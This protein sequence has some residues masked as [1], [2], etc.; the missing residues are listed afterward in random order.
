[1]RISMFLMA[2]FVA[3][4]LAQVPDTVPDYSWYTGNSSPYTISTARQLAGLARI[5]N[6][7]AGGINT[8][9]F[10][11]KEIKLT[12]NIDLSEYANW[13]PIGYNINNLSTS[14]PFKGTF[15][16]NG[17]VIKNLKIE[18]NSNAHYQGLF[19]TLSSG[20][21]ENLGVEVDIRNSSG[22]GQFYGAIAGS[23]ESGSIIRNCYSIGYISAYATVGGIAGNVDNST[24]ENCWS[25]VNLSGNSFGFE[26][27]QGGHTG[28]IVGQAYNSYTIK[29]C[30]AFMNSVTKTYGPDSTF[31]RIVGFIGTGG[32]GVLS[33]NIAYSGMT[34]PGSIISANNSQDGLS[35]TID[36]LQTASDFPTALTDDPWTYVPG[37]LPGFGE[38]VDM[39]AHLENK[40]IVTKESANF[41]A[42]RN[43]K[44]IE[45]NTAI[46]T[47]VN[48]IRDSC[49]TLCT[50]QFG[51]GT[52]VLDILQDTVSFNNTSSTWGTINLTGKITSSKK[53]APTIHI[54]L[55]SSGDL[56]VNINADIANTADSSNAV[57]LNNSRAVN[58]TGGKIEANSL[59]SY[60]AIAS[61]STAVVTISGAAE[62]TAR[63]TLGSSHAIRQSIGTININGGKVFAPEKL[64]IY[65]NG[66][67]T[68]NVNGGEISASKHTVIINESGTIN[69]NGGMV[70]AEACSG[71]YAIENRTGTINVNGGTV[72]AK[73]KYAI[74]NN[75]TQSTVILD[76]DPTITGEIL[77]HF[78]N[79]SVTKTFAPVGSKIYNISFYGEHTYGL[80]AVV[81]GAPHIANFTPSGFP[82]NKDL[83]LAVSGDDII[84]SSQFSIYEDEWY[85][86]TSKEDLKKLAD[87]VNN[88]KTNPIYANENVRYILT[89]DIDLS[90]YENWTPIGNDKFPFKNS[91][92]NGDAHV[93][94]NLT[95]TDGGDNKGLFGV[96]DGAYIENIGIENANIIGGNNVG[97]VAGSAQGS[98]I[99]NC[100]VTGR[101]RG[102]TYVGGVAGAPVSHIGKCWSSAT[103]SGVDHV[104][105]IIGTGGTVQK[106]VALGMIVRTSGSNE[107]FGRIHS[108]GNETA[109]SDNTAYAGML[110]NGETVDPSDADAISKHGNND[111]NF[112]DFDK[113]INE[114]KTIWTKGVDKLPG[115]G[116]AI[117]MPPH[118]GSPDTAAML[119]A[120]ERIRIAIQDAI[121]TQAKASDETNAENEI[122]AII[123]S[124]NLDS[125]ITV[126]IE[127]T[128]LTANVD[129]NVSVTNPFGEKGKYE[130]KVKLT[131]NIK[132]LED[133][134][135]I[136][137]T[138]TPYNFG[139]GDGSSDK[140]YEIITEEHLAN[141]ATLINNSTTNEF[142][143]GKVHNDG[144]NIYVYDG[145]H[146]KL[147]DSLDLSSYNWVPIGRTSAAHAFKGTFDGN[148][149]VISNLKVNTTSDAGLFG[150]SVC[151]TIKNVG[152]ENVDVFSDGNHT[153][154][155]VGIIEN[156]YNF[157][158]DL[159][160]NVYVTGEVSGGKNTGGIVG[161]SEIKIQ[162]SWSTAKVKSTSSSYT[163]N[164]LGYSKNNSAVPV[165][166]AALGDSII[167]ENNFG[168]IYGTNLNPSPSTLNNVAFAGMLVNDKKVTGKENDRNGKNITADSI[169]H[170]GTIGGLFTDTAIWT[171][172]NG[173]LPGFGKP[174]DMPDYLLKD[175]LNSMKFM[176]MVDSATTNFYVL[177]KLANSNNID[178]ADARDTVINFIKE[179][180]GANIPVEI[181]DDSFAMATEGTTSSLLGENGSY[182]FK[183][184]IDGTGLESKLCS[185]TI[186]ATPHI[187]FA[188]GGGG[189]EK[190][191]YEIANAGQLDIL[192]QRVNVENSSVTSKYYKLVDDIDLNAYTNWIP[193]G[194][195]SDYSFKGVF[196]GDGYTIKNLIINTS[197]SGR[198]LFGYINGGTVKNL[199]LEKVDISGNAYE[200]G[201]I[202]GS[203]SNGSVIENS[204]VIG[205]VKG[206]NNVGGIVGLN[207]GSTIKS[208]WTSVNVEGANYVGGIAGKMDNGS[209][210]ENCVAFGEKI[211]SAG[212]S[213]G[214]IAGNSIG[215]SGNIAFAQMK[216]NGDVV[217]GNSNDKHG[218]DKTINNLLMI[219]NYPASFNDAPWIFRNIPNLRTQI[220]MPEHLNLSP[221]TINIYKD[222]TEWDNWASEGKA[223]ALWLNADS[224]TEVIIKEGGSEVTKS[225]TPGT[226]Y[227]Y[228]CEHECRNSTRV[229][230]GYSISVASHEIT[231]DYYTIIFEA[232]TD[233]DVLRMSTVT[234]TYNEKDIKSGDIVLKGGNLTL[235][236]NGLGSGAYTY[237]WTGSGISDSFSDLLEI[238]S[239]S[240]SI[241]AICTI[242]GTGV[243]LL[244][245]TLQINNE[246]PEIGDKLSIELTNHNYNGKLGYT[247]LRINPTN[248]GSTELDYEPTYQVNAGDLDYGIMVKVTAP[249][250]SGTLTVT[251]NP[252]T[253]R[254]PTIT[255]FT[256]DIPQ[257]HV[258]D[259]GN[260]NG[261]GEVTGADGMGTIT[262][263]YNGK[264]TIPTNAGTYTITVDIEDGTVYKETTELI[265]GDY[266]IAQAQG[267]FTPKILNLTYNPNT[268]KLSHLNIANYEWKADTTALQMG[269]YE[270]P[271]TYTDPSGNYIP[272]DGN[273]TITL[274]KALGITVDA[275]TLSSKTTDSITII[276]VSTSNGQSAE[277]S[278]N[279][280]AT[281]QTSLTFSG[282]E[283]NTTYNIIARS[284]E[285]G[286]YNAGTP[287]NV[288]SVTTK[289]T[290]TAADIAFAIPSHTYNGTQQ[291]ID[292]T[293]TKFGTITIYYNEG[294]SKP[295]NAGTYTIKVNVTGGDDFSSANNIELGK[296]T[297]AKKELSITGFTITKPYDA[298]TTVLSLGTLQFS[299]FENSETAIVN[300][301]DVTA[302]YSAANAGE[303]IDINFTGNFAMSSGTADSNN[304]KI[305]QPTGITG[306]ITKIA[307]TLTFEIPTN[308]VYSGE[309]LGFS[310]DA[311]TTV[312]YNGNTTPPTNA[313]TYKVTINIKETTNYTAKNDTLDDYIIAKATGTWRSHGHIIYEYAEGLTLNNLPLDSG[314]AW[315]TKTT[316]LTK[317]NNQSFPA[318]YTD[319]SGNYLPVQGMIR[320]SISA[321]TPIL[322]NSQLSTLNSQL[323]QYYSL[324]GIPLGSQKPTAPGVYIEKIGHQIR[325]V[326]VK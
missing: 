309:Q 42:R 319:T 262:V 318:I 199:G 90:T 19:G 323:P 244:L 184:S 81:N 30:A 113:N 4:V 16:G 54:N 172:E 253:K 146:Y 175:A 231:L 198:G 190:Y 86:I 173:K 195:I 103:V 260:T 52:S 18:I 143:S 325:K 106:N 140:P 279:N 50:I 84:I 160:S 224:S 232:E 153:G 55:A 44:E 112:D 47:V 41:I 161:Y 233:N 149:K 293:E 87:L 57:Y 101:V 104:G 48:T 201:S 35:K 102:E 221:I 62:I 174:V 281:W 129:Y 115:F 8:S 226:W 176:D 274:S 6:G 294:T 128:S 302:T 237:A 39:P 285:N 92:F 120:M 249:G 275:P 280:G 193:I 88:D 196:D 131:K 209:I 162:N 165:N 34:I 13:T 236:A 119:Y 117:D 256:Y 135:D 211:I 227:I 137:V 254:T 234:A 268:T 14:N 297:I 60:S 1:M 133:N 310:I 156:Y 313:G 259:D 91:I 251:T 77:T 267:T 292:I 130:F 255:D 10:Y 67:G 45:K 301:S 99:N 94:S 89:E 121:L 245:G 155:I 304:Y 315:I 272:V 36:Q 107:T 69:V 261:I 132:S 51:D 71:C 188:S 17:K 95:I 65:N 152:L 296:Y 248:A 22:T 247:W 240:N 194:R 61:I 9:N 64:A 126:D 326:I 150:R 278:I 111:M 80:V 189:V 277:Y 171:A 311:N 239:L 136:A 300:I 307:P 222:G 205:E 78:G 182:K 258:Y 228:E 213:I 291:G 218:T 122:K 85:Q 109:A 177:Q 219:S 127:S 187:S 220:E 53:S 70:S 98:T 180:A 151:G 266:T 197:V 28:G 145:K 288:L 235:V 215:L 123:V 147:M 252:V 317:G 164:I 320:V 105:G 230:T 273:I 223:F 170:D 241:N 312:Y 93:I 314:Y 299:G 295:V 46:Q 37:K 23:M 306:K 217:N 31:N 15:N 322:S 124:L 29:N 56:A 5:V 203:I 100:Y 243:N 200:L 216:V 158:K 157:C 298:T 191:P 73:Q 210:V 12:D 148:G 114:N 308:H 181:K 24:V 225:V 25:T 58:I 108:G 202:A 183:I 270:Y 63:G 305:T 282:L 83:V 276:A 284:K 324:K 40:Y 167:S 97:I 49:A 208:S 321:P 20:K 75:T 116:S 303:N 125:E 185:L 263:K 204:Y 257:D 269:E 96:T 316:A 283:E 142:Y 179:L 7:T 72:S 265:L 21:V 118:I 178:S 76:G 68:V 139:G 59:K 242:T 286:N 11:G 43:E 214:R 74:H 229:V 66:S 3:Q 154:A 2:I 82:E 27:N 159:I 163:G 26:Y 287:S 186:I 271:A 168:R 110:V 264:T 238:H 141:M 246:N 169:L 207:E 289:K 212:D 79:L 206:I 166:C 138:A 144:I 250:R 32:T 33:N 38:A 290:P 192:R 134:F